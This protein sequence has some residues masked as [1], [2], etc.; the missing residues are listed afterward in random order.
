[1]FGISMAGYNAMASSLLALLSL[2]ASL[3]PRRRR[4]IPHI[5]RPV[6]A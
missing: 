1:M 5:P 4:R 6:T 2:I 3:R